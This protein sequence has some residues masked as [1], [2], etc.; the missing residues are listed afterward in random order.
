MKTIRI[1]FLVVLA[2]VF[3][4]VAAFALHGQA[5]SRIATGT[6]DDLQMPA[7]SLAGN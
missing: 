3:L 5:P 2:N 4:F 6:L 7:P 1:P